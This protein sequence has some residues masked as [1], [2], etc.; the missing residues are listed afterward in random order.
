MHLVVFTTSIDYLKDEQKDSVMGYRIEASLIDGKP[1]LKI[2]NTN[3]Q[4][5]CLSWT[6]CGKHGEEQSQQEIQQLFR[7]L[8][9]LTC[10]QDIANV[11]LF[12]LSPLKTD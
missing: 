5:P 2:Y 4:L 3:Q 1:S 11:R 10:K 6:Y 12:N 9:L 8:L 7:Q